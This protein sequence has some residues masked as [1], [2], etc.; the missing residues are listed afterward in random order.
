MVH[1]IQ[2][3]LDSEIESKEAKIVDVH[4]K[5]RLGTGVKVLLTAI[6]A[7]AVAAGIYAAFVFST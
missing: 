7:V 1:E 5:Q 4:T 2:G 6:V 3:E